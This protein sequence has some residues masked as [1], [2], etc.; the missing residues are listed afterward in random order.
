MFLDMDQFKRVS[1]DGITEPIPVNEQTATV[2]ELE[3]D[4]LTE[5]AYLEPGNKVKGAFFKFITCDSIAPLVRRWVE[6]KPWLAS[7]R[8][9]EGH[10]PVQVASPVCRNIF[11]LKWMS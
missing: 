5:A 7:H 4:T 3:S 2:R 11:G 9:D 8:S 6:T 1:V 10:V